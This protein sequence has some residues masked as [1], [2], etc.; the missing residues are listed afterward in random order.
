VPYEDVL[1]IA[2]L[3]LT[4]T[5]ESVKDG[6][7]EL[8]AVRALKGKFEGAAATVAFSG[9]FRDGEGPEKGKPAALLCLRLEDGKLRLAGD[10]PKGGGFVVEGPKLA[11]KLL[12]AAADPAKAFAADDAA[13]KLSA[14]YRLSRAWLAAPE[15]K[16]PAPPEGL[17]E[18]LVEGLIP[19]DLRGRGVNSAARDAVNA[20]L[21]CEINNAPLRYSVNAEEITRSTKGEDVKSEWDY[22][23]RRVK[24]LRER[25]KEKAE[26]KPPP[27]PAKE[28]KL[29]EPFFNL[30]LVKLFVPV[31]AP[32]PP[33]P[34]PPEKKAEPPPPAAKS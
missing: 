32:T 1:D 10:P 23:V 34:P 15:D 18:T 33:A 24:A 17:V 29:P 3:A 31:P 30:E 6:K 22:A 4:G 28:R 19:G 5:V 26:G 2:D 16:K 7:I 12:A 25:E 14:A 20:L 8:S 11:E 21:K 9:S 27:D 13:A